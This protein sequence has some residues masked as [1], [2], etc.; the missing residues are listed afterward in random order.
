MTTLKPM[1]ADTIV[2]ECHICHR[3]DKPENM[4]K[5]VILVRGKE[6]EGFSHRD[7]YD[8]YRTKAARSIYKYRD[9]ADKRKSFEEWR[10]DTGY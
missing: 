4:A 5:V 2:V 6:E 3:K 8:R 1:T 7:C 10:K 9:R